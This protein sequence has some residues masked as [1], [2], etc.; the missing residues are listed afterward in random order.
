MIVSH[1]YPHMT[2]VVKPLPFSC[3]HLQNA[4]QSPFQEVWERLVAPDPSNL[5]EHNYQGVEKVGTTYY[6]SYQLLLVNFAR[7]TLKNCKQVD[8][9]RKHYENIMERREKDQEESSKKGIVE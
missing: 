6:P 1:F 8:K 2:S 3:S 9:P 5:V 4:Q 7:F